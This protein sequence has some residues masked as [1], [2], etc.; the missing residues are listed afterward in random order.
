MAVVE[1]PPSTISDTIDTP[2]TEG[3]L[4][5]KSSPIEMAPN[6]HR[7]LYQATVEDDPEDSSN[8]KRNSQSNNSSD[9]SAASSVVSDSMSSKVSNMS[10][11]R[12]SGSGVLR[13]P[14]SQPSSPRK[15]PTVRFSDRGPVV[16]NGRPSPTQT[17]QE[18]TTPRREAFDFA[19]EGTQL[20]AVDLK[21]GTLFDDKGEPTRRLGEFL[22][23]IANYV[24]SHRCNISR[25]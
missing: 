19:V 11:K 24:V 7:K 2:S 1:N 12:L 22:R 23:G 25:H 17:S 3:A 5:P 8:P 9:C 14:G 10:A 6:P 4:S 16:L 20:S 18:P 21:W 15:R 13:S